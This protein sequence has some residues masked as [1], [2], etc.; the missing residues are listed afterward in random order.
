MR[1]AQK[2]NWRPLAIVACALVSACGATVPPS[3]TPDPNLTAP[4]GGATATPVT[5]AS[6]STGP[7]LEGTLVCVGTDLVFPAD[8]FSL[9]VGAETG[10]DAAALA[11]RDL[12]ASETGSQLGLP[13]S[14]WRLVSADDT[15][16][17]YLGVGPAGSAFVTLV[18][19]AAGWEMNEGGECAL[20]VQPP[21]GAGYAT[22]RID[23]TSSPTAA[24]TQVAVLAIEMACAG[25][26]APLGRLLPPI[27]LTT[28]EAVTI[29]L[30]VRTA[31]GANDCPGN[32]EVPVMVDLGGAL[33]SRHLFDGS[34]VP[35]IQ[36]STATTARR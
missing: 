26:A 2:R 28:D 7:S 15:H 8:V 36:R 22:W 23:P 9:P 19:G 10:P 21:A 34:S 12:V 5:S 27:V 14:G 3:S 1:W 35:P 4:P 33:G 6:A 16:A 17:R 11:L 13:R 31:P 25:G 30:F 32:P 24:S 20:A 18:I 29:A